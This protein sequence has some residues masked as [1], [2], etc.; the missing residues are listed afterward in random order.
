MVLSFLS[1]SAFCP[2]LVNQTMD[3]V[4]TEHHVFR[5]SL[6]VDHNQNTA[7]Y[8]YVCSCVLLFSMD[9]NA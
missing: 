4:Q 7:A 3:E 5:L 9:G 1:R 8:S 6:E 2:V